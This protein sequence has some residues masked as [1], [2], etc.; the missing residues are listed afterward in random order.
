MYN[1]YRVTPYNG[2]PRDFNTHKRAIAAVESI[3]YQ[4]NEC[5]L[6]I[7]VITPNSTV[8]ESYILQSFQYDAK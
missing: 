6:D 5:T 2:Q 1:I 3:T 8:D 7:L 4:G